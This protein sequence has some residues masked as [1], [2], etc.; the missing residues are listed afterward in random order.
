M[1]TPLKYIYNDLFF[2][3]FNA[4]AG[5]VV[6]GWK[7]KAFNKAVQNEDWPHMELKQRMRHLSTCLYNQLDGSFS[8]KLSAVL[9]MVTVIKQ[10]SKVTYSG[11]AYMFIP[12]FVEQYGL[13]DMERSFKAM[14]AISMISSCEFAIR[15]FLLKDQQRVM[16]QMLKWSK[17]PHQNLRRFS[18]EGCRPRLPWAMAI[19][20]LKKDPLP[21]L[22]ILENLKADESL[23]V[24]KSVANNLNDIS[25]DHPALI[26]SVIKQWKGHNSITGWILKHGSRGLL[27]TG[28]EEVLELFGTG[29]NV[30]CTI[31][32]VKLNKKKLL[33]GESLS[34]E[35]DLHLKETSARNLRIEYLIYF[36]KPG[37]T[38]SKKIFKINERNYKPGRHTF[39]KL[40]SFKDLTTRKHYPGTHS[41]AIVIN[42]KEKIR[43]EFD[44]LVS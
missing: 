10:G 21:I 39:K 40:H 4:V 1:A 7:T 33:I 25:K 16:E 44:L 6:H 3:E 14:E 12:D 32:S 9:K 41:L 38:N 2:K 29:G 23:F 22:P 28:H 43:V 42:G 13:D 35:F 26:L 18:S 11:L 17:D 19:P 8:R 37:K 27:K 31:S 5:S 34:F 36:K 30:N 24:Q 20:S 15:P